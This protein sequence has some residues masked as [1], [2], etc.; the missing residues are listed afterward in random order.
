MIETKVV[1][2]FPAAHMPAS[3][4]SKLPSL[5]TPTASWEVTV[6]SGSPHRPVNAGRKGYPCTPLNRE[7]G[8]F[9]LPRRAGLSKQETDVVLR[10]Q[11][12]NNAGKI[13]YVRAK[14]LFMKSLKCMG[15]CTRDQGVGTESS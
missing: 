5:V 4:M 12:K 8:S 1:P 14:Q 7:N 13:F 9:R 10:T 15:G 2:H 3:F 6:L 11:R